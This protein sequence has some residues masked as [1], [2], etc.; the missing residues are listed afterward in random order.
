MTTFIDS[1]VLFAVLNDKERHHAWATKEL[2]ACKARGPAIICDIVYS[3]LSVGMAT[4]ADVDAVI[5]QLDLERYT[6]DDASL[7]VAGKAFLKYRKTHNGQKTN[8]L[9]DF[10]I[11]AVAETQ[12][13]PLMTANEKDFKTY[14]PGVTFIVP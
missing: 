14:F 9:P 7:F 4:Q 2:E 3:E 13:A 5:A 11:G 12:G 10:L 6:F 8:V 1:S